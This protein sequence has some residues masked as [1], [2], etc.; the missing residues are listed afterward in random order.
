MYLLFV[1]GS[2]LTSLET[3]QAEVC[4]CIHTEQEIATYP[5][6]DHLQYEKL[7]AIKAWGGLGMWLS[8]KSISQH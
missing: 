8:K 5:G 2:A 6:F 3:T 7:Q 1:E 4:V